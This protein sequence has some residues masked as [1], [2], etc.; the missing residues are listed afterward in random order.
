MFA[1]PCGYGNS[2]GKR[3]ELNAPWGTQASRT[4][5]RQNAIKQPHSGIQTLWGH[6][7]IPYQCQPHNSLFQVQLILMRL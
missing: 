5:V 6:D 1:Y 7:L 4:E 2:L 3:H